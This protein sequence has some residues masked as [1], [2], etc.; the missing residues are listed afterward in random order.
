MSAAATPAASAASTASTAS[1][2]DR[3]WFAPAAAGRLATVRVAAAL[4]GLLLL[5]TWVADYPLW[6]G[7][8]GIVTPE[9]LEAWRA[10][11]AV[12]LHDLAAGGNGGRLLLLLQAVALVLLGLG[13]AT[14]LA[15][16]AAA[17]LHASLLHRGPMLAGPGDDVLAVVLWC[18]VVGRPGDALSVDRSLAAKGGGTPAPSWRNRTAL[19]LLRIHAS[20]LAAAAVVSQLKAD[21]WWNGS[22]AW[23]LAAREGSRLDI[24]SALASSEYLTN[25]LTHA[26]TLFEIGF[27]AGVWPRRTRRVTA[28]A[29]IVGWPLLG[30]LAGEPAWGAAMAILALACLP[31]RGE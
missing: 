29:G 17:I 27:A 20:V 1:A 28:L 2:W 31:A 9:V 30:L 6:F 5:W 10:P 25:V 7:A 3:F 11:T 21:V 12:S 16:P 14:P 26:I 13:A 4:L 15:A 18:L 8:G 19:E 23:H 22:A 24:A